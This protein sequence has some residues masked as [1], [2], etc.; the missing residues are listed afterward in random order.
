MQKFLTFLFLPLLTLFYLLLAMVMGKKHSYPLSFFLVFVFLFLFF[1]YFFFL[2]L[3]EKESKLK[4]DFFSLLAGFLGGFSL[5]LFYF[6]QGSYIPPQSDLIFLFLLMPFFTFILVFFFDKIRSLQLKKE[7]QSKANILDFSYTPLWLAHLFGFFS[8]V[9]VLSNLERPSSF[10]PLVRFFNLEVFPLVS[11]VLLAFS[12]ACFVL[13]A[14]FFN[15]GFTDDFNWLLGFVSSGFLFSFFWLMS[16]GSRLVIEISLLPLPLV[17]SAMLAIF[18]G[19]LK[20]WRSEFKNFL[21]KLH[22]VYFS[23]LLMVMIF[24]PL[25]RL[26]ETFLFSPLVLKGVAGGAGLFLISLVVGTL[27]LPALPRGR[28]G[29]ILPG[30]VLAIFSLIVLASPY[31]QYSVSGR[32]G[33]AINFSK[34]WI[35]PGYEFV[36]PWL[37]LLTAF[38]LLYASRLGKIDLLKSFVCLICLSIFSSWLARSRLWNWFS[39]LPPEVSEAVGTEY[40]NWQEKL[41]AGF[42]YRFSLFII[43]LAAAAGLVYFFVES[44]KEKRKEKKL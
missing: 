38:L 13:K 22:F 14:R 28:F 27:K 18:F 26:K 42:Y 40:L 21:S 16:S 15:E 39:F 1:I 2:K 25:E 9:S 6:R 36:V 8:A 4:M 29:L 11:S 19:F 12:L 44:F 23:P 5:P 20:A 7:T 31:C 43:V 3:K 34:S 35:S 10:A 37:F 30:M 41:L 17:I 33:S 24:A 32:P